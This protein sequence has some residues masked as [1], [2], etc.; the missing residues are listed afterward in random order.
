MIL[1]GF[2]LENERKA[3]MQYLKNELPT[4]LLIDEIETL[5]K[6]ISD[7]DDWSGFNSKLQ[8]IR[9]FRGLF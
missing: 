3:E 7:N 6:Q 8:A 1:D 2:E 4:T 9:N 5:W